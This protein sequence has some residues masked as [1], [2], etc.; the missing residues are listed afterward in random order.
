MPQYSVDEVLEII[1]SLADDEQIDLRTKRPA[2]WA[3]LQPGSMPLTVQRSQSIGD[4]SMGSGNTFDLNQLAADL[5][6][7]E[8]RV[9]KRLGAAIAL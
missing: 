9:A 3:Q 6:G 1:K 4:L 2:V 7:P 8:T 5:S